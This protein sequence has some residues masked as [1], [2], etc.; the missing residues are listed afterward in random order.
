M[1]VGFTDTFDTDT[2]D[3]IV[4]SAFSLQAQ[5]TR[6]LFGN[7]RALLDRRLRGALAGSEPVGRETRRTKKRGKLIRYA[8]G[9]VAVLNVANRRMFAVAY[10]RMG[11]DLIA[12]SS[13]DDLRASLDLLW[14]AVFSY[15]QLRPVAM[16]L[17]GS[18]LARVDHRA[19]A[20]L[21]K[22]IV[23]SF[24]ARVRAG[25]VSRELRI[26]LHPGYLADIDMQEVADFIRNL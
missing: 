6:E 24:V 26:V 21:L 23:R 20:D 19:R 22:L 2:D 17:V 11:N 3:D 8:L 1:V 10:A 12:R 7:D 16:P 13:P 4:I 9:T 25:P 18:A 15:G 14:S 5:A